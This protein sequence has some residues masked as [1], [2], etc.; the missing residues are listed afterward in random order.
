MLYHGLWQTEEMVD[1]MLM[2]MKTDSEKKKALKCQLQFRKLILEQKADKRM[3]QLSEKGKQYS[4]NKL[5]ENVKEL[6]RSALNI[7]KEPIHSMFVGKRVVHYQLVENV[8]TPF[9]GFVISVVPG[10]PQWH[11]VTY[12][13]DSE[14]YVYKLA[15]D[16]AAGDLEIVIQGSIASDSSFQTVIC[17]VVI[18]YLQEMLIISRKRVVHGHFLTFSHL[19]TTYATCKLP[20]SG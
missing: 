2:E 16:Y 5:T 3:F 17:Y 18:I 13:N 14:I 11:N 7:H 6:V 20:G 12:D 9:H 19:S 8:R 15:D 1:S 4:V 10:Y